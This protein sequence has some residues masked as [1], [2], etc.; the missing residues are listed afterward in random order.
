MDCQLYTWGAED[1]IRGGYKPAQ[2][3]QALA[4]IGAS[5]RVDVIRLCFEFLRLNI[6][7]PLDSSSEIIS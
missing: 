2:K 5:P 7:L 1:Q 3:C 6:E 4:R